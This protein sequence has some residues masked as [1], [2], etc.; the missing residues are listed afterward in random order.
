MTQYVQV[1]VPEH[2]VPAVMSLI[3]KGVTQEA[4]SLAWSEKEIRRI[5]SES[6]ENMRRALVLLA[7]NSGSP[8]SGTTIAREALGISEKGYT[9]AGMMGAFSRRMKGRHGGRNPIV[10]EFDS[11]DRT[12]R[13]SIVSPEVS[14]IILR[15]ANL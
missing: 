4:P 5:W 3:M 8:V 13:Y 7:S 6:A 1:P 12:W 9:V 2:L 10:A 14:Q 15:L 11:L